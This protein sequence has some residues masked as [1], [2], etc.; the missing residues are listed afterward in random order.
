[1]SPSQPVYPRIHSAR[2]W[3]KS[4]VKLH[5]CQTASTFM[6][7]RLVQIGDGNAD[8]RLVDMFEEAREDSPIAYAALSYVWGTSNDTLTTTRENIDD[9]KRQ[10]PFERLPMVRMMPCGPHLCSHAL[11][12]AG[13]Q[14]IQDAILLCRGLLIP[15]LWVDGL[16]IVQ[17]DLEDHDWNE[18][19]AKMSQIY[20]NAHLTISAEDTPASNVGF[21]QLFR[22]PFR[23]L[24]GQKEGTEFGVWMRGTQSQTTSEDILSTRAWTLQERILSNRVLRF[25]SSGM[26]WECNNCILRE[27]RA[28]VPDL[29]SLTFRAIRLSGG[30][31]GHESFTRRRP[32]GEA[33]WDNSIGEKA[34]HVSYFLISS[35]PASIYYAWYAV[36]ENYSR[37]AMTS[38]TDKLSAISG[39]VRFLADCRKLGPEDYLAGLWRGDIAGGLLWYTVPSKPEDDHYRH[40]DQYIAPSWSWASLNG[41]IA[42]FHEQYQFPLDIRINFVHGEC[43]PVST[44]RYGRVRFGAITLRG[45][46]TPVDLLVLPYD[47]EICP[48][49][50]TGGIGCAPRAH[51][52]Q[53][54]LISNAIPDK[55]T[56]RSWYEILPD[57]AMEYDTPE[58]IEPFRLEPGK[59]MP[60]KSPQDMGGGS[61]E[62]KHFCL[63][64]GEMVDRQSHGR[65]HWWLVLEQAG[66]EEAPVYR[67]VGVGYFQYLRRPFQLFGFD[68]TNAVTIL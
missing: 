19:S 53:L 61:D 59:K 2:W 24:P 64:I 56:R 49:D 54:V 62:T 8:V 26:E 22:N 32:D 52:E 6:P 34:I 3:L 17:R 55:N 10:L 36:V 13:M 46:L 60:W 18:E 20:F 33:R 7:R 50:Y 39:L 63:S 11:R 31:V 38:V 14:T 35:S 12:Q 41:P 27:S 47:P 58:T 44:D 15:W 30:A 51:P 57:V 42:Y 43:Y 25:R 4:C 40:T 1:M 29:Q 16:C 21:D 23:T 66:E 9:H 68:E 37:R 45:T 5:K 67:R 28:L 65:R 48:S